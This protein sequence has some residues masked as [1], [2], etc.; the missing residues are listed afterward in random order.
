MSNIINIG[1]TSGGSG[2]SVVANPQG[3]AT[4]TLNKLQVDGT[5]YGVSGGGSATHNYSTTEQ[6]VGT[7]IDGKTLYEKTVSFT[8]PS[9]NNYT[10]QSLGLL[11]NDIDTIFVQSGYVSKGENVAS[12]GAYASSVA[13]EQCVGFIYKGTTNI[14]FDYRVG[15]SYYAGSSNLTIRYTKTTT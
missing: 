1:G 13:P 3:A 8:T 4:D 12:W 15:S 7:W 5:I 2:S 11:T 6:V 9:T 10:Q 14:S